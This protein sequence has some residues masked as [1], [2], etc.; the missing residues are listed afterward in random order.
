MSVPITILN[1]P[2]ITLILIRAHS[3][4]LSVQFDLL[5]A[6]VILLDM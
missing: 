2:V 3:T 5:L 4:I 6:V 1:H